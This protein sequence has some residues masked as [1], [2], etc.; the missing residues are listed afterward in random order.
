M[1]EL[2]CLAYSIFVELNLSGG[3]GFGSLVIK[4]AAF[5]ALIDI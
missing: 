4:F 5:K 3:F 2:P 1:P